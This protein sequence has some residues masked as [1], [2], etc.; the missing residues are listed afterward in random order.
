[1]HENRET[2]V[3]PAVQ[4]GSRS[5]GDGLGRTARMHV[6]EESDSDILPRNHSNKDG[7]SS[8][9]SQEGRLLIK[10]AFHLTRTRH[11]AGL[12]VSSRWRVCG[13]ANAW[14]DIHPR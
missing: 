6:I 3:T 1:M 4:F 10:N 11:S 8:A 2:S 14:P 13:Q 12:R 7:T 9:E 5:A